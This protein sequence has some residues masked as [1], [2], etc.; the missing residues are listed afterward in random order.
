MAAQ[1]PLQKPATVQEYMERPDEDESVRKWKESLLGNPADQDPKLTCPPDDKR[2]FIPKIFKVI[3][4]GGPTY[5]Y[6]LQNPAELEGLKKKG[7]LLKEGQ[8]FHYQLT[9]LVHHEIILGL[10]LKTKSKK[11]MHSEEADFDLGSYPPTAAPIVRDLD[12]CEVPKG[13]MSRGE[14]KC[15]SVIEDDMGRT[16]FKFDAKFKIS[17]DK[18]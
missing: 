3:V 13:M 8:T 9:F 17:K 2:I 11:L 6:D 5:T 10:K 15:S 14:Y 18:D 16:H 1:T 7:Y 4:E 12:D